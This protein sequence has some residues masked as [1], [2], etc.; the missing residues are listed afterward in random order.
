MD[1][2]LTKLLLFSILMGIPI[3]AVLSVSF[4]AL[5]AAA[6]SVITATL[7]LV[8]MWSVLHSRKMLFWQH[9]KSQA[10]LLADSSCAVLD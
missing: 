6:G 2:I 4:G 5:G 9:V 1:A 3:T 10:P 8:A 7:I